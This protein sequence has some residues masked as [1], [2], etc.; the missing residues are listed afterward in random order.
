MVAWTPERTDLLRTLFAEKLT[1]TQIAC[2]LGG[3]T[4]NAV[5]GKVGRLKLNAVPGEGFS[6]NGFGGARAARQRKPRRTMVRT[7]NHGNRFDRV[8]VDVPDPLPAE[9]IFEIPVGQRCLLMDLND[10]KCRWPVGQPGTPAFFFCGGLPTDGLPYC[11]YHSRVAYQPAAARRSRS[12]RGH[13][14]Y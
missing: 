2:E 13:G 3:V 6:G 12:N 4:R 7:V 8:V 1:A 14:R 5:I 9:P 10:S 11:G